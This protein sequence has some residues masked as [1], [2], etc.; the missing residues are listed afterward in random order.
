M[1]VKSINNPSIN[2]ELFTYHYLLMA[3][4]LSAYASLDCG[5]L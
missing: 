4:Y 1:H 3:N 5:Q 2:H